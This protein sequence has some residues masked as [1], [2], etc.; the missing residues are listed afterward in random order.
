MRQIEEMIRAGKNI[1]DIIEEAKKVELQIEKERQ[2][3]EKKK[4]ARA[5]LKTSLCKYM[6]A[7]HPKISNMSDVA[8]NLIEL[9][10]ECASYS[11]LIKSIR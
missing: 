11:L 10:D 5:D 9:V 6:A 3:Q 1:E 8:E 2:K 4:C 7:V